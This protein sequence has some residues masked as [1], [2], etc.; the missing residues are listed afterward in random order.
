[1]FSICDNCALNYG[2]IGSP[3]ERVSK[4]KPFINEY[5][6]EGITYP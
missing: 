5:K 1:M 3:P 6:W 4:I 2:E